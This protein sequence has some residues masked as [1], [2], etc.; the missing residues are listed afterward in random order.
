ML[1]LYSE[2]SLQHL[3]WRNDE[4]VRKWCRHSTLITEA[5]HRYWL[6]KIERDPTSLYL[7]VMEDSVDVGTVGLTDIDYINGTAEFNI[8]IDPLEQGKGYGKQ[9]LILLL[10]L[11]FN[12][13][14]LRL[15]WGE[16]IEGNPA[17]EI[18]KKIGFKID[19]ILRQRYFKDGHLRSATLVSIKREEMILC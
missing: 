16:V 3:D 15:V 7:G 4:R 5:T 14:R 1:H 6:E 2:I 17:L 8:L 10:K 9:S 13:L 19:G 12:E 18:F 11:A